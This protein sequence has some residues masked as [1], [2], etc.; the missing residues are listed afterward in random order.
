LAGW[1]ALL[2][3]SAIAKDEVYGLGRP[4]TSGEIADLDTDVRFDGQGLP[5]GSGSAAAGKALY[6]EQCAACHGGDLKGVKAAGAR[7]FLGDGMTV[8]NHWPHAPTLFDYIRRA[9][10]FLTPRSLT[11]D[12]VYAVTAYILAEAG[13][14]AEDT[15]LD[16]ATLSSVEMP[17]RDGFAADPR[18]DVSSHP[19][20]KHPGR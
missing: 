5:P 20:P 8:Q 15:V 12:Q 10:P 14:V 6:I 16:A 1:L 9:M 13:I 4:A 3:G 19:G 17:N 7:G 11:D 18:P 2:S